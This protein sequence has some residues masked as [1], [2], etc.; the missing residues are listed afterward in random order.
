MILKK[1]LFFFDE[2]CLGYTTLV[3]LVTLD[4]VQSLLLNHS[5]QS[6]LFHPSKECMRLRRIYYSSLAR[7]VF[8]TGLPEDTLLTDFMSPLTQS[9][10]NMKTISSLHSFQSV[11]VKV[12]FEFTRDDTNGFI[13]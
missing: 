2:L 9:L 3:M 10:E 4:N 5:K 1:T 6:F 12:V 13:L 8:S 7:I 11:Q